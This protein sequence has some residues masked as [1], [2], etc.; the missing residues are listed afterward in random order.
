MKAVIIVCICALLGACASASTIAE[1]CRERGLLIVD[2]N[3][4]QCRMLIRD[5]VAQQ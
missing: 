1:A 2:K 3:V 4:Y 5:G